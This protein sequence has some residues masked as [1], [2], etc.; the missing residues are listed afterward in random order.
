MMQDCAG[1]DVLQHLAAAGPNIEI[2]RDFL[3][4]GASVHL[5]NRSGNT[6]LFMAAAAGLKDHVG[7]LKAAGAHLH[8]DE[9][10][11]AR[12]HASEGDGNAAIWE[13]VI[14]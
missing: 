7:I 5:R 6:P 13:Q 14:G 2:L 10:A 11:A 1:A 3:E 4:Q 8:S 12:L 9:T